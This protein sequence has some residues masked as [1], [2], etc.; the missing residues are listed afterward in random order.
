MILGEMRELGQESRGLHA[1]IAQQ[2]AE[3]GAKQCY[4]VGAEWTGVVPEKQHFND[5]Q[6]CAEY[7]DSH[8]LTGCDVLLKGSHGVALEQLEPY[9][10]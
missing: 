8:P 4:F 7:L 2:A 6:A 1:R 3:S 10:L 9:L 5:C